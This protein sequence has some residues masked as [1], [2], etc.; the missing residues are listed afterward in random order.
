MAD[1][2]KNPKTEADEVKYVDDYPID[3]TNEESLVRQKDLDRGQEL[4]KSFGFDNVSYESKDIEKIKEETKD[5]EPKLESKENI[6]ETYSKSDSLTRGQRTYTS[7][8]SKDIRVEK[9]P[10][11]DRE[12]VGKISTEAREIPA[13]TKLVIESDNGNIKTNQSHISTSSKNHAR[14]KIYYDTYDKDSLHEPSYKQRSIDPTRIPYSDYQ[15]EADYELAGIHYGARQNSYVLDDI[16]IDPTNM[17][18]IDVLPIKSHYKAMKKT[19]TYSLPW[20]KIGL[21]VAASLGAIKLIT[22]LTD[23]DEKEFFWQ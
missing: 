15:K 5:I 20:K 3:K 13:E 19:K 23:D 14:S 17:K 1:K 22:S 12:V 10:T 21:G 2:N 9:T 18:R 8:S 11:S 16:R 4:Y 7:S 6:E